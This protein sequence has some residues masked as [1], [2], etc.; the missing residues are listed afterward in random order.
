MVV[1]GPQNN[2]SKMVSEDRST[3][4]LDTPLGWVEANG[5]VTAKDGLTALREPLHGHRAGHCASRD[6]RRVTEGLRVLDSMWAAAHYLMSRTADF[7]NPLSCLGFRF[8]KAKVVLHPVGKC[9][10]HAPCCIG[11]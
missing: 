8:E 10:S 7:V 6:V 4:A 9:N 1:G 11:L 2:F 5:R 3:G